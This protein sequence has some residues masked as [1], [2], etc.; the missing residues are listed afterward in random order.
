LALT[1]FFLLSLRGFQQGQD[2]QSQS[3][4]ILIIIRANCNTIMQ[5]KTITVRLSTDELET[6]EKFQKNYKIKSQN[7][8]IRIATGFFINMTETMSKVVTSPEINF[9]INQLNAYL[10]GELEKV[11]EVKADLKGKFDLYEQQ[12]F[13]QMEK[14]MDKGVAEIAPFTQERSAGRPPQPKAGPGRP[15]E[16]EY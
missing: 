3:V 14:I 1:Y 16:K 5:S 9:Q 8:F 10:R 4:V 7:D 15:K 2:S 6:I 11:P 13:P 12:I